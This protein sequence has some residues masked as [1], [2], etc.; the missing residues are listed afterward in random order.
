MKKSKGAQG[1][2]DA[3]NPDDST[4]W[5]KLCISGKTSKLPVESLKSYLRFF[6]IT[7]SG[8]KDTLIWRIKLH[9]KSLG[10]SVD[11]QNP[12][13]LKAA[14]LRKA[15]ASRGL[16][17]IGDN[18]E[19]LERLVEYVIQ[20][21]K[22]ESSSA[23]VIEEE[24][25][26]AQSSGGK[27]NDQSFGVQ[28]AQKILE[29]A[30]EEDFEGILS[31]A[32]S[33]VSKSTPT[34]VLRKAYLKLSLLIHPDKIGSKFSQ[35]T[36]AFQALVEAF[37]QLSKHDEPASEEVQNKKTGKKK[38]KIVSIMRSNEGCYRTQL[39]C[40]RC[41]QEW[42]LAVTG[43]QPYYYNFM[44]QGLKTYSCA[45]CLL[46]FGCVTA[47]HKCPHCKRNFEYDPND[48]HRKITCGNKGCTLEFGFWMYTVSDRVMNDLGEELKKETW[49]RLK[50]REAKQRRAKRANRNGLEAFEGSVRELQEQMYL[51]DLFDQCPRCGLQLE[52]E[53]DG[54]TARQEHLQNCNNEEE[55]GH[56]QKKLRVE[57]SKKQ[58]REDKEAAQSDLQA[59][60]AWEFLGSQNSSLYL[61]S[62][63]QLQE[64]LGNFQKNTTGLNKEQLIAEL[65]KVRKNIDEGNLLTDGKNPAQSSI[66]PSNKQTDVLPPN[67]HEME[68]EQLRSVCASYG[69][70]VRSNASK[71]SMIRAIEDRLFPQEESLMLISDK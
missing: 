23:P 56:Y 42:G 47:N 29:L 67:L 48:Y 51:R 39:F 16:S 17:P 63:N 41:R 27:K 22:P 20:N 60:R 5:N 15:V 19:L 70:S 62:E 46:S 35:A 61:L 53:E 45:T 7:Q 36:K 30:E 68:A 10:H 25:N 37:E 49:Q 11:G 9:L 28:M 13:N 34:A 43:V 50:A 31:L 12:F 40:P 54:R 38:N 26:S 2:P 4:A 57:E 14:E 33:S 59:L 66:F 64:K 1:G 3:P 52:E 6:G 58:Q 71:S 65:V 21:N 55:I 8:Q 44:M 24:A 18:D 69:I 32:E